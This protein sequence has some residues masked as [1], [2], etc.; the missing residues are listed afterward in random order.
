[1]TDLKTCA[2]NWRSHLERVSDDYPHM[3]GV[4]LARQLAAELLR[5]MES[6]APSQS[7]VD[8]LLRGLAD[9]THAGY[10]WLELEVC[11]RQWAQERGFMPVDVA[12][13]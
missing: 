3:P 11:A 7:E 6:P 4:E 10:A 2:A 8:A 1:M 13:P 9:H 5:L 12:Q